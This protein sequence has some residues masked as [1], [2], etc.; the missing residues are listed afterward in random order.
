MQAN[1]AGYCRAENE[2]KLY[3]II[4]PFINSMYYDA[5]PQY[6][7]APSCVADYFALD[8]CRRSVIIEV[9]NWFIT[10]KDMEQLTKYLVHATELYGENKFKIVVIAG[11]VMQTRRAILEKLGIEIILT[12]DLNQ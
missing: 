8:T 9:K 12:R 6:P 1:P 11:G 3:E 2:Y 7:F 4:Q 10:I 5:K